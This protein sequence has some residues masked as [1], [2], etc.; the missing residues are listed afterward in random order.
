M[1]RAIIFW[2]FRP[3]YILEAC[4]IVFAVSAAIAIDERIRYI[5]HLND[6]PADGGIFTCALCQGTVTILSDWR[7]LARA[8][9]AESAATTV[10]DRHTRTRDGEVRLV[11]PSRA[12][13]SKAL[14]TRH[15]MYEMMN[16]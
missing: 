7:K 1:K 4:R 11:I 9:Q 3:A 12:R 2:I 8:R 15:C 5:T 16:P 14:I 6:T 13:D 10:V